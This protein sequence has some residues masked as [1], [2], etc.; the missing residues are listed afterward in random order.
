MAR[1]PIVIS[2]HPSAWMCDNGG[3][4]EGGPATPGNSCQFCGQP[5]AGW[6]EPYH[7][8][9][10][11][12]DNAPANLAVACPLCHLPQHLNRAEIDRESV[13]VWLPEM[14]QAALNILARQIHLACIETRLPAAYEH[15]ARMR[16][17]SMGSSAAF[18]AYRTVYER[19]SAAQ[20][21]LGTSSPRLLGAALRAMPKAQY[22]KRDDLLGGVRLLPLGHLYRAGRDIYPDILRSWAVPGRQSGGERGNAQ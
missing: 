4:A 19:S 13:L 12:A 17:P 10:N 18:Q 8:N 20:I 15:M 16:S 9:D 11:H 6:Q 14:S 22:E 21:R 2:A 7:L 1:L 5:T 3:N